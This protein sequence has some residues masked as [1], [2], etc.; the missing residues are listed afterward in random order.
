VTHNVTMTTPEPRTRRC[1]SCGSRFVV[2]HYDQ[3]YCS[4]IWPG[5]SSV[6]SLIF[7]AQQADAQQR[8]AQGS[9]R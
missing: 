3:A 7:A 2:E 9:H 1:P 8:F 6:Y 4:G 5:T